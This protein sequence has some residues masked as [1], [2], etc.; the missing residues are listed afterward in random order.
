M[1]IDMYTWS[2]VY[3]INVYDQ[4]EIV[5]TDYNQPGQRIKEIIEIIVVKSYD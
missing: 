1:Y 4:R 2:W 3:L 5:I